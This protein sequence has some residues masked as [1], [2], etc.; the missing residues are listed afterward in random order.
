MAG[1][2]GFTEAQKAAN[3]RY[4]KSGKTRRVELTVNA[5][6]WNIWEEYAA[7]KGMSRA[8]MIRDCVSH[9][10]KADGWEIR[11]E[12]PIAPEQAVPPKRKRGRPRKAESE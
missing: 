6:D 11:A 8:T 1:Y 12:E 10:M 5:E 7:S 2:K 9:C 3:E 4:R